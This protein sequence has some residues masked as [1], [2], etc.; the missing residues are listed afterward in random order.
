[1]NTEN[2]D[3]PIGPQ[4]LPGTLSPKAECFIQFDK[5]SPI[6]IFEGRGDVRFDIYPGGEI[7]WEDGKGK[8][9][10]IFLKKK[11]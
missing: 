5:D 11:T 3:R 1:M 10:R 2:L 7:S 4:T 8:T 6:K 9:F